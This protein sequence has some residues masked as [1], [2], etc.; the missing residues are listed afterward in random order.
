MII[1]KNLPEEFKKLT[2]FVC[3]RYEQRDGKTTKVLKI[4]GEF[5]KDGSPS[6]AMSNNAKT[7]RTFEK[8]VEFYQK[9]GTVYDGIGFVP[10]PEQGYVLIDI[11]ECVTENGISRNAQQI[12][13]HFGSTYAEK[14]VSGTGLHI[15]CKGNITGYVIKTGS[16][17]GSKTDID[18]IKEIEVYHKGRFFTF[19]GN[20]VSTS[21]DIAECQA[22]IDWLFSAYPALNKKAIQPEKVRPVPVPSVVNLSD[23]EII[24]TI[25]RSKNSRLFEKLY[26]RGDTSG[27]INKKTGADN[28]HSA[29]DLAL[30]N[31]LPFYCRG[32]GETMRRIFSASALGQRD[33]WRTRK[34]YQDRTI[35]EALRTWD[36][37]IYDPAEYARQKTIEAL[38]GGEAP[39]GEPEAQPGEVLDP[40]EW[41]PEDFRNREKL[42]AVFDCVY[43]NNDDELL[44]ALK[45]RASDLKIP[46][47]SQ[48]WTKYRNERKKKESAA[49]VAE[50]IGRMDLLP[51]AYGLKTGSYHITTKG[52]I[53]EVEGKEEIKIV[54]V[55]PVPVLPTAILTNI[56]TG[57]VKTRL[58]WKAENK[59]AHEEIFENR[60]LADKSKIMYLADRGLPV[61]STNA[62]D[63]VEYL[64]TIA[65][66]NVD[67]LPDEKSVSSLGWHDDNK[68][69]SPYDD[70][71]TIDNITENITI[72][73]SVKSKGSLEEWAAFMAQHM[74][75]KRL[76]IVM[77]ASFG[78]V[79]LRLV[80][81]LPFILHLWGKTGTGKTVGL[82]CA[83]AVWGNPEPGA[84]LRS[85]DATTNATMRLAGFLRNLPV[86]ADEMQTV[87]DREGDYDKFI[88]RTCEGVERGR[89]NAN[90]SLKPLQEWNCIFIT[91][92]EEPI[93]NI[94]S[95]AGAVN[96]VIEVELD[97][98]ELLFPGN[99][100]NEVA[101]FCREHYG[102]AG[103]ELVR[104]IKTL[105]ADILKEAYKTCSKTLMKNGITAKQALSAATVIIG[106]RLM[107]RFI[108]G[109]TVEPLQPDDILP[110]L[111]T[112]F[113]VD[114]AE[115]AYSTL[116]NL[117]AANRNRF[118]SKKDTGTMVYEY[119]PVQGE[120]WGKIFEGGYFVNKSILERELQNIGFQFNAVKKAWAEK[121]YLIKDNKGGYYHQRYEEGARC[122]YIYMVTGQET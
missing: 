52:I 11:D 36:G 105:G 43:A 46:R 93:V 106:S 121:G 86:V 53:K 55:I 37:T 12:L 111:K 74:T 15:I 115:R 122:E 81:A 5:K 65:D 60:T 6:N 71:L 2:Q 87:R 59:P 97:T 104:Q 42:L 119:E 33:K 89:L 28:D 57:Y 84:Y 120:T 16:R 96:R 50:E 32:N 90:G 118:M 80:G 47:I 73:R 78:S 98:S 7:W 4:P 83:A 68:K 66:Q 1:Y 29:A 99:L 94:K 40:G 75:D 41:Q 34:D 38:T 8:T 10:K 35:Q 22:A 88:M 30:M 103:P 19:T 79:I 116:M 62:L 26:D 72:F 9:Y 21:S 117:F 109:Q 91:S 49:V 13:E 69:F 77:A 101:N 114:P 18:G 45:N 27:Y 56:E 17:T 64:E 39:A 61:N 82:M 48:R 107:C 14:S 76:H 20:L 67:K 31:I 63:V 24:D 92:G 113:T 100:G 102:T 110:Y 51:E 3:W 44:E 85:M 70:D 112:E 54:N 58:W 95:G 25:R 23:M 108:L